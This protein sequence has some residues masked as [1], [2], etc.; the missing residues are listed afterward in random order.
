MGRLGRLVRQRSRRRNS[1]AKGLGIRVPCI[2]ISPY[3]KKGFVSHTTYEFG[4]VL[5]LVEQTFNLPVVGPPSFGYTDTRASSMVDAFDFTQKPRA[6]QK[7]HAK[8]P[9]THFLK[10]TPPSAPPT[11]TKALSPT[12][13]LSSRAECPEGY[14]CEAP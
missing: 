4:S 10:P 6:Y 13:A 8:Y 2:I 12:V 7:I 5:K 14:R 9:P 1:I 3:A 11:T